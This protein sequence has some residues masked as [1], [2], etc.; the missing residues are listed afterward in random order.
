M[1]Q[2]RQKV[3]FEVG[4]PVVVE[5]E[6]NDGQAVAGKFGDQY[7]YF[8][9]GNRI[10]WVDPAIREMIVNTNAKAGDQVAIQKVEIKN[11]NKKRVA[12]QVA[13]IQRDDE[14]ERPPVVSSAP[15]AQAPQ[16][17]P[18]PPP[19]RG[20]QA[21]PAAQEG[22][23]PAPQARAFTSEAAYAARIA[24]LE[25]ALTE[26]AFKKEQ[27]SAALRKAID[28]EIEATR[29][30]PQQK[31][32]SRS[33]LLETALITAIEAVHAAEAHA[34]ERLRFTSEDVRALAITLYIEIG[35]SS[36]KGGRA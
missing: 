23:K 20:A 35:K 8:L 32:G 27:T 17:A 28:A 14:A 30:K 21:H 33:A 10:M 19:A 2:E 26:M 5:L 36:G 3:T 34:G 4:K 29:S 16:P 6:F 11:G 15:R 9:G 1:Q 12:W 22:E 31:I 18:A 24:E 7:Q 13:R 25:T